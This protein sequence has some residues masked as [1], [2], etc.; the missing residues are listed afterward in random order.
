[1]GKAPSVTETL[2][3]LVPIVLV[4]A[5]LG[6]WSRR[7]QRAALSHQNALEGLTE[8]E[9]AA[10]K[11]AVRTGQR[12]SDPAL[13]H[14][15][16]A[17]AESRAVVHRR[18]LREAERA[19][20]LLIGLGLAL[21]AIGAVALADEF[22]ILGLVLLVVGLL[23]GPASLVGIRRHRRGVAAAEAALE[24]NSSSADRG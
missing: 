6:W 21:A 13:T 2:I 15:A 5:A 10:V 24:A 18:R 14:R 17:W 11:A 12:V 23:Y 8:A 4:A 9:R 22:S 7:G 3:A 1:M 20:W 19:K 16:T